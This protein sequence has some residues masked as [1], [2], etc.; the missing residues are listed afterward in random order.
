MGCK[1]PRPTYQMGGIAE[2]TDTYWKCKCGFK[3]ALAN[4]FCGGRG[5]I[6][7]KA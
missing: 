6:G 5:T 4:E 3:N 7:C 1:K 2:L